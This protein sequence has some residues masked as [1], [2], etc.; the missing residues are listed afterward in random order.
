M[1]GFGLADLLAARAGEEFELHAR[2]INP[3]FVRMLRTI[4]FDRHWA[5]G[6]GAYL[7]D[8]DGN[9]FLDLLG[10]FGMYNV[11]RSNERVRSALAEALELEL[12]GR[13]ALGVTQL[14]GLLA[15]ELLAVAPPSV[16]RV[17]FT[18]SGT[19]AVEA[20]LKLG[21]AATGRSR[22]VSLENGFHGLTLG[23]LS[24]NGGRDFTDE[25][26]PLLPG[27]VRVPANDLEALEAEL[28][29]E[30]V[31]LFVVEPV[32]GH[33]VLLHEPGYLAGAQELCR[34]YG[35][36][37]CVDE[38][39][40]GFGRTG[41][42]L[43][44]EHWGLEPDLV[45]VAKSLSGGYVPVGALLLRREVFDAVFDS[46][47]HSVRHGSTFA[48]NDLA[49]V[50]GLATLREL[51]E[52]GLVERAARVGELLL[53]RTRPLVDRY[54]VVRDVRGLGLMWGIE[55]AEPA[56]RR[57]AS[58]K[59]IERAQA[60]L[61]SQLV[62]VPLFTEHRIL[63]QVAGHR[64]NVVRAMPPLVL[65]EADVDEFAGALD[66]V[67]AKAEKIPR[68][69]VGFALRAARAGRSDRSRTRA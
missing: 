50:A 53:E 42:M 8:R 14:A 39:A 23:A 22:V 9:R 68:A 58:W 47:E 60:G 43:A 66:A 4:G 19:E 46:M 29:R 17:L 63:I 38:V 57:R 41:R 15:E 20:A 45:T 54:E 6:D 34:R 26:E 52:G 7:Y 56:G 64:M 11:G 24:A 51:R 69:M 27:F 31:A 65:S 35:T 32:V 48:P 21:R 5:R 67:L 33:G 18:S 10:G 55:F 40:T 44:L 16:G 36:L 13:V 59:L 3:Q 1:S 30:D 28:R 2:T 25:F 12:P 37:L 49:M 62:V 61:F